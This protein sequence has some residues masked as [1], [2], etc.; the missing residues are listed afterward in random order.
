MQL[1]NFFRLI[2]T[3]V[4]LMALPA[5]VAMFFELQNEAKI[6]PVKSEKMLSINR[7]LRL[8]FFGIGLGAFLNALFSLLLILNFDFN[9]IPLVGGVAFN[10]RNLVINSFFTFSSWSFFLIKNKLENK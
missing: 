10:M 2:N 4:A 9:L 3:T 1:V 6:I 8:I 5:S 7:I